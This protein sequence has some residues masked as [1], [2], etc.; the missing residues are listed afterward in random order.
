MKSGVRR[1]SQDLS[2][3]TS[4]DGTRGPQPEFVEVLEARLSRRSLLHGAAGVSAVTAMGGAGSLFSPPASAAAASA[5]DFQ[6]LERIY[7]E[8]HHVSSG[9]RTSVLLRW[10]DPIL[11]GAPAFD[12]NNQSKEAQSKQFGYNCDYTAFLP[13]PYGS[14]NSEHGLLCVNHEY[15][16]NHIMFPGWIGEAWASSPDLTQSQAD[17]LMASVGHAVVEIVK[18][19]GEWRVVADSNLN[20]RISLFTE[21][22][23]SGP[24]AGHDMVKTSADPSG[25]KPVG[26]HTNCSGGVTP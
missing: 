1:T 7:D 19:D 9:Y 17:S 26:T 25:T 23:M 10:G 5:F 6:E 16:S 4:R 12:P 20:R 14:D 22:A 8:T 3:R 2:D 24:A 11:A 18:T 15:P 13:L 21:M